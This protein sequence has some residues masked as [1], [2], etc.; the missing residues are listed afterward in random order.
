MRLQG[1]FAKCFAFTEMSSGVELAG[2]VVP[3]TKLKRKRAKEKM[4][5]EIKIH[6][7]LNHVGIVAYK[8]FFEDSANVYL[9]LELCKNKVRVRSLPAFE[10]AKCSLHY[11]R[12]PLPHPLPSP[13]CA[14]R[15]PRTLV[16]DNDGADEGAA[17]AD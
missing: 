10:R 6:R 17:H 3:K 13:V 12:S 9:M 11:F 14:A 8:G 2:K 5:A 4:I 16:S 1:G 7:P 15:S